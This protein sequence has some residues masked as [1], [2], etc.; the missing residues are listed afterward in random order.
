M[1]ASAA[2]EIMAAPRSCQRRADSADPTIRPEPMPF[3]F[4]AAMTLS[5]AASNVGVG[6]VKHAAPGR[7]L[8]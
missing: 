3:F 4:A 7:A 8:P 6:V 1:R 2:S 5:T